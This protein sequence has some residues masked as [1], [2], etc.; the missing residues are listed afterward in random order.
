[1]RVLML[2]HNLREHGTW[3]RAFA[4]GRELA[5]KGHDVTLFT[6]SP[7]RW[8]R[9][10]EKKEAGMT[11]V[12]T[13]NWNPLV[14]K[15]D[16]WGPLD[17]AYRLGRVLLQPYDVLYAFAHPP[18]VYLPAQLARRTFRRPLVVDW[19]DLYGEGIFPVREADRYYHGHQSPQLAIQRRCEKMETRLE[20]E[21]LRKADS[22]TVI[23]SELERQARKVNAAVP[24]LRYPCGA[25][26]DDFFPRPKAECRRELELPEEGLFLGYIANYNPD[27]RFFLDTLARVFEARPDARLLSTAPPLSA[28]AREA[29]GLKQEN[30]LEIGRQPFERLNTVLNAADILL[31][32]LED[33]PSNQARWPHKFGDYLAAGKP[34]VTNFVGDILHYFPSVDEPNRIGIAAPA[35]PQAFADAIC[36][37]GRHPKWWDEMGRQSRL[38]AT[39]KLSWATLAEDVEKFLIQNLHQVKGTKR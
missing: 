22:I 15:D 13:P 4:I 24:L 29:Y 16:G 19:C 25:N 37:L 8:Y 17:T 21:I 33:N 23:S 31:L 20:K 12:E 35:R 14:H 11:I 18:N 6:V 2:N 38:L 30:L 7:D 26:M 27:E 5:R 10:Q 39:E 1:M 28:R 36:D 3:F 32:P 9:V 34:I